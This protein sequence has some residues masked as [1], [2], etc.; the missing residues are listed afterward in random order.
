MKSV[1][2]RLVNVF[3]LVLLVFAAGPVYASPD[4]LRATL[5]NG[6]RVIIERNTLAPVATVEVNYLVGSID[7]PEGF[8]GTAH[9][10][11]HMLFRGSPGLSADQL[12]VLIADLGGDFNADTQQAVT[13][14][15]FT[16]PAGLVDV[17]LRIEAIRMSGVFDSQDLWEK[18]RGAIEQEVVQDLSSPMYLFESQVIGELFSGTPYAEDALGSKETFDKTTGAMLKS[19]YDAWYAPNNAVLV[20]A[21]NVDPAR[22]LELVKSVFGPLA[23]KTLPARRSVELKPVKASSF[24]LDTDLPYGL[25]ALSYRLPGYDSPDYA[26]GQVLADV[27]D[28][29]RSNLADLVARGQALFAGFDGSSL[30]KSSY[31]YAIAAIPASADGP[32][33]VET[34]RAVIDDTAKNGVPA[35]LV[36]ASKRHEISDAEFRRNSI[37]GLA[38]EWSQAVAVEGRN[39]PDDDI[40]AVRKVTKADVDRVAR[41]YLRNDASVSA[42]LR[43]SPTGSPASVAPSSARGP[44]SFTPQ[45]TKPVML[46]DWAKKAAALPDVPAGTAG[47]AVT[48]LPNG[49]RLMVLPTDISNTVTVLGKVKNNADLQVP[50]GKEG[51]EDI[52]ESLFSYGTASYDRLAFQ[53]ALDE[54]GAEEAGGAGFSLR[55]LPDRFDRVMQLLAEHLQRP[56]LPESAFSIVRKSVTDAIAGR[57]TSPSYLSTRALETHLF[58]PK[59]KALREATQKSTG[60]VTLDDVRSYYRQ[61]F[62]PDM[63]TMIVIGKITP[64]QARKTVQHY[65]GSWK[66]EGRKPETDLPPVPP[67]GPSAVAVPDPSRVQ[68]LATLAETL[69]INRR[70]PDYYPLELGRHVLSGAF[71]ATRLYRDLREESGLVYT[72]EAELEAGKTRALFVVDYACDPPNVSKAR[73]IVERNLKDLQTTPVTAD[74]LQRAKTLLI[75]RIELSRSSVDGIAGEYLHLALEDLPLDEPYHAATQ[76]RSLTADDVRNA[77][78]KWIRPQ[79]FVQVTVGPTE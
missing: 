24:D 27:L 1:K 59:D 36:E 30:P 10:Q 7:A 74:E 33:M 11:E 22:T 70:H 45:S 16:V 37:S 8:P 65:F 49:L 14:Y 39:S 29:K 76:Y 17:A 6:L 23:P 73:S 2:H 46:P 58:P 44:E 43:T 61:V 13:Q 71:Y 3:I 12:S 42:V 50:A 54:I 28:S 25:A 79:D 63:T 18:E 26:A 53:A 62:R 68:T 20:I 56:A 78:R 55:V 38:A 75:R 32:A 5:P 51:V 21:G 31:G 57:M 48:V 77:Y 67:N 19:F 35:E 9:A 15:F 60:S 52:L 72:V 69:G 40:D 34:L 41:Q 64:E 66:A 4:V 47:P